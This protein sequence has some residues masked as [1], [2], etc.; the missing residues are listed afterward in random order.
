MSRVSKLQKAH[1]AQRRAQSGR[2]ARGH[3]RS[4]REL[5]AR[6]QRPS[7]CGCGHYDH[8]EYG[9]LQGCAWNDC[10]ARAP[11]WG[12]QTPSPFGTDLF[13]ALAFALGA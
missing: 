11:K 2:W 8:G 1:A 6:R 4:R 12:V 7:R 10:G 13:G 3:A 9:C 5:A